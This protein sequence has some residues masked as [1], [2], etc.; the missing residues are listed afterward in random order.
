MAFAASAGGPSDAW[1]PLQARATRRHRFTISAVQR[2]ICATGHSY[3]SDLPVPSVGL[4]S[5]PSTAAWSSR[6]EQGIVITLPRS[7]TDQEGRGRSVAIPRIGGSHC[8]VDALDGWQSTS[9]IVDGPLFRPVSKAGKVTG[10]H[11]R[12]ALSRPL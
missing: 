8:P 2:E 6:R 4:N 9:G 12:R 10:T 11:Y 7:K 5:P 1:A 3:L